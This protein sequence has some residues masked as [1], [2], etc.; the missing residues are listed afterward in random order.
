MQRTL[1]ILGLIFVGL[2]GVVAM[3]RAVGFGASAR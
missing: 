1:V 2:G 3:D